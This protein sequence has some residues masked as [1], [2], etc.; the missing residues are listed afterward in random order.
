MNNPTPEQLARLPKYAQEYIW[1]L[2]LKAVRAERDL[3]AWTVK[4]TKTK[5]WTTD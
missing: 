4:Q 3:K 1:E 5:E 2:Q